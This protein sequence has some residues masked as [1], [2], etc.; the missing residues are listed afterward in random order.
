MQANL[1]VEREISTCCR[2]QSLIRSDEVGF[3]YSLWGSST[4]WRWRWWWWF[5]RWIGEKRR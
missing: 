1:M 4:E 3:R 5:G 2:V